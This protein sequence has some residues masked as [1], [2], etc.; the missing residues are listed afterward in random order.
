MDDININSSTIQH[1]TGSSLAFSAGKVTINGKLDATQLIVNGSVVEASVSEL[2][3]MKGVTADKDDINKLNGLTATQQ[4]L[5]FVSGATGNLQN[6]INN[7]LS[8]S[9]A[10]NTF[11]PKAGSSSIVTVGAL[12]SGSIT[13]NFGSI[14]T[15]SSSITTSGAMYA[16]SLEVDNLVLNS[17]NI[18]HASNPGLLTLN[19]DSLVIGSNTTINAGLAVN[20]L[21]LGNTTVTSSAS[22]LN[23]PNT[24]VLVQ[25][26]LVQIRICKWSYKFYSNTIK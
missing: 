18:G 24:M 8:S 12:D 5:N 6:Q 20:N 22:D 15:G 21:T 14:N 13:S 4:E 1:S 10:T 2:N 19:S 23:K 9:D 26:P 16:G 17:S 7:L 11:A 3:I 25:H